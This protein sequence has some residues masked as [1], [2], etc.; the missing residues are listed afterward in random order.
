MFLVKLCTQD[1]SESPQ[2][3]L[4]SVLDLSN[5]SNGCNPCLVT[6]CEDMLR[7][8]FAS[9]DPTVGATGVVDGCWR[10]A[11]A[12]LKS[13]EHLRFVRGMCMCGTVHIII[14][15]IYCIYWG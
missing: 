6:T 4:P 11:W 7:T 2:L 10:R 5:A 14:Y 8:V 12:A 9:D 1:D 13:L 3:S 15:G